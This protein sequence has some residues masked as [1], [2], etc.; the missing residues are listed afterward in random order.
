M[1]ICN[2]LKCRAIN[3][4]LSIFYFLNK[5]MICFWFLHFCI[6][7]FLHYPFFSAYFVFLLLSLL[8]VECRLRLCG[9]PLPLLNNCLLSLINVECRWRLCGLPLPLPLLNNCLLSLVNVYRVGLTTKISGVL[10]IILFYST[11]HL[12]PQNVIQFPTTALVRPINAYFLMWL[13][14]LSAPI[15]EE[16]DML[17]A[18]VNKLAKVQQSRNMQFR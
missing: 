13:H 4:V 7:T 8:D 5:Y 17:L 12:Y 18:K 3:S 9:L 11:R 10:T 14:K 15:F 2:I 1:F 6:S 16:H